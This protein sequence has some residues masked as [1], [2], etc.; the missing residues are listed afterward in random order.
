MSKK[1]LI[2]ICFLL[3]LS[4]SYLLEAQLKNS[5]WNQQTTLQPRRLPLPDDLQKIV[6]IDLD[7]DGD[8]D[9]IK[10]NIQKGI[11]VMWVDDN[12]NMQWSNIEGD[13]VGD[14]LLVDK[15]N[16]GKFSGPEDLSIK[17]VDNNGDGKADM[18]FIV[19]NGKA[20]V[21][22]AFDWK[23]NIIM[24]LD[25]DQNGIFKYIDWNLMVT[26]AWEH[27]G[28]S[29]FFTDYQGN[30]LFTKIS[31]SSFRISDLRYSWEN[32]FI[33]WDYD[34]DGLSEMAVRM[35]DLPFILNQKPGGYMSEALKA[36]IFKPEYRTGKVNDSIFAKQ[37]NEID[38]V[39][40]GQINYVAI[41]YDLDNDNGQGNEFDFDMS[42]CFEGEGFKYSDQV[43]K[44]PKLRG[45]PAA[46]SLLFDASW[47][48]L[49]E[50][51]YPNRKTA[52]DLTFNRGKWNNCYLVFD[53]DDDCNRW[54]RVEFYEP[55][56]LFKTGG[57]KGGIDTNIQA[58][59]VGD[60]GEF[61]MDFS[62]KGNLYI[63]AFDG[64]I[65]LHGAEWG[66]W[67]IDQTAF[68]IQG[69]GGIYDLWGPNRT[70]TLPPRFGTVKYSD[71]D[72]NGFYDTIEN[73]LNGD[74]IFETT[75]S[76][77]ALGIDDWQPVICTAGLNYKDFTKL[78]KKTTEEN[79]IR[80]QQAIGIS[81]KK[82]IS[83]AWYAFWK[84]PRTLHEKYD[85][86]YWLNF[87]IYNDM[88]QIALAKG[89][90]ANVKLIDKAYYSGNWA[91]LK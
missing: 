49:T 53:E 1:N 28:H 13:M 82:G 37:S 62:G 73:D 29:N 63:G 78:F 76:L 61:D 47:R 32:P 24:L 51:I 59:A 50:L 31:A 71:S 2:L 65:H 45:L 88:R 91:L 5:F 12:D 44:F 86:A 90:T 22:N 46:D 25:D 39:P 33:F 4:E 7:K 18:Q 57:R 55:K 79:W 83:T 64:K 67:R 20:D 74:S 27:N 40:S 84:M 16:D 38:I 52:L 66:A 8:P 19:E 54:E 9:I 72:N 17:W 23:S 75:V 56:D 58:D 36:F 30:I 68:S 85:Y 42:L 3:F 87:Y 15:N 80:A 10:Y 11:P 14:C 41:T 70:Q 43:N 89:E 6:R 35:L 81:Q 69:F 48:K 77:R 26:R 60:R 21:R 34:R